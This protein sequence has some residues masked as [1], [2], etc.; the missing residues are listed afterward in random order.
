MYLFFWQCFVGYQ[1]QMYCILTTIV[2]HLLPNIFGYK[3][4]DNMYI[5]TNWHSWL[6]QWD[7]QQERYRPHREEGIQAIVSIV[8]GVVTNGQGRVLDLACGCGS[9]SMRLLTQL[10]HL[11]IVAVDRDPVL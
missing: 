5:P 2:M 3:I 4:G 9:I 6:E 7:K 11:D 10:P 8:E 1:N